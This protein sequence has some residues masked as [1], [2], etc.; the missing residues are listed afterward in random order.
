M[1][2]CLLAAPDNIVALNN[3]ARLETAQPLGRGR[4]EAERIWRR[5]LQLDSGNSDA[6][7]NLG[8]LLSFEAGTADEACA[9]LQRAL[10]RLPDDVE[11]LD[12]LATLLMRMPESR[13]EALQLFRRTVAIDAGGH[14]G[15]A[16]GHGGVEGG[17][18]GVAGGF[19]GVAGGLGG[20]AGGI[21][22]VE[23]GLSGDAGGG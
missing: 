16:G 18:N 10:Q 1:R 22:G 3:L 23:V 17:L 9:L 7:R 21:G 8:T 2:R 5:V 12:S 19:G 4:K 20:N 14:G 13:A 11:L 6:L 15:N